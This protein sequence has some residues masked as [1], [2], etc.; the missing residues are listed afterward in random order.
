MTWQGV[1][2]PIEVHR[3]T[4]KVEVVVE[5]ARHYAKNKNCRPIWTVS[6]YRPNPLSDIV[7]TAKESGQEILNALKQA[8]IVA[9]PLITPHAKFIQD[10]LAQVL[11]SPLNRAYSLLNLASESTS[12]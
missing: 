1:W 6:D 3:G 4:Q 10:P 8:G 11:V 2:L 12:E 7:K 5:K 9:Q